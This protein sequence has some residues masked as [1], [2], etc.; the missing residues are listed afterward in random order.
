MWKPLLNYFSKKKPKIEYYMEPDEGSNYT[1]TSRITY[2]KIK[3]YV[4]GRYG[5]N[6]YMSYIAQV[7]RLYG[8]DMGENYNK[9]KKE[10]P[11]VKQWPQEK[12]GYIKEALEHCGLS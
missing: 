2:H 8:L 7:K 4:K 6:V 11:D 1:P 9:S 10:N 12:M 5:V 3:E